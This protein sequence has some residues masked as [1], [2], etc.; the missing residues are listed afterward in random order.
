MRNP[1]ISFFLAI[2]C[3]VIV[4]SCSEEKKDPRLSYR[5][6]YDG[7]GYLN[8]E[9]TDEV[10]AAFPDLISV[11]DANGVLET[12][13]RNLVA[14]IGKAVVIM[15]KAEDPYGTLHSYYTDELMFYSGR[16]TVSVWLNGERTDLDGAWQNGWLTNEELKI[17]FHNL[18]LAGYLHPKYSG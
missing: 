9:L 18:K 11:A 14:L 13:E 12:G 7:Q 15:E 1:F 6:I 2:F 3:L 16:N 4:S 5:D 10:S 17:V 8:A